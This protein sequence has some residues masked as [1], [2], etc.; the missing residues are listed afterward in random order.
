MIFRKSFLQQIHFVVQI[1]EYISSYISV[2]V[3][4]YYIYLLFSSQS[5]LLALARLAAHICKTVELLSERQRM[6][7]SADN[8]TI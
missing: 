2:T 8:P 5:P 1:Y 6:S 3:L 4:K 7:R